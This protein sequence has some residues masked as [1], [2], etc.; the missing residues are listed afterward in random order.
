MTATATL[1]APVR[2]QTRPTRNSREASK[3]LNDI[4]EQSHKFKFWALEENSVLLPAVTVSEGA[5]MIT[6]TVPLD[7][8]DMRQVFVFATPRSILVE[9]LRKCL[10]NHCG[11]IASEV[12]RNR[13][14]RELKFRCGLA[15]GTTAARLAG[16]CLE[17]TSIK[18]VI[19]GDEAW[20]EFIQMDTRSSLGPCDRTNS[21]ARV[22]AHPGL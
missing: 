4:R 21:P 9:V 7:D 1:L 16:G 10:L 14:T 12:Q 5:T 17:I 19:T 13:I 2:Q 11:P 15:K 3:H 8:V 6:V 22:A 20:S 18:A